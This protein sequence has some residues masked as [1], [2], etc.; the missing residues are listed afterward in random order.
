[1]SDKMDERDFSD[2][3]IDVSMWKKLLKIFRPYYK[4]V[5]ILCLFNALIAL[6]DT[7]FPVLNKYALD[8]YID[9]SVPNS[10][11]IRF[12]LI[13]LALILV[14]TF[15]HMFFFK[16]A[17]KAEMGYSHD[18]REK[19]FKKLQ[20]LSFAYY[21]VTPVGWLVSRLTSDIF[22]LSE[23]IAWSFAEFA[24]GIPMMV[25]A[26]AVMF[27]Y[28]TT[29]TWIVLASVP[30]IAVITFYFDKKML[31][32]YREVRK[33]N[34]IITN[35]YS[36]GINGA[37]TTKT[38]V[39]EDNNFKEFKQESENFKGSAIKAAYIGS[40]F[41]PLV[42]F[43]SSLCLSFIAYKGGSMVFEMTITFGTLMMFVQYAQQFF[44]PLRTLSMI[45][46]D[47]QMAQASGERIVYLLDQEPKITDK[48]EVIEKYGTL[49]E[50]KTENYEKIKGDI[51]FEH[52]DF[53]Y[54]KEEPVLSDFNLKVKAGQ[55]IALVGETGGGKSTIVNLLCRFYE[56]VNGKL[57]IDGKDYRER[58]IGWL[59]NN[60][61]YV[62]QAPHLFSGTVL[63]NIKYGSP[64]A[65]MDEIINAARLVNAHQFITELK[66]GY[67]T[68]VGEN[69]SKLS[70]GQKQLVCFAR[71][72][73]KNPSIFILDEATA[74]IDSETEAIIQYAIENIMKGKTSFVI[75]HRLST[76]VNCD[77]I[78]VI[79]HGKI[80]EDGNH[81]KL[82]SEKS[83]YYSL[84][85][86]QFNE[87]VID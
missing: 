63:D 24:W 11:L 60:L 66:D 68:E 19:C 22:R 55:T 16:V 72:V 49:F 8:Y 28:N 50:P 43:I 33:L 17:G 26:T 59:H 36:E 40:L 44:E 4:H 35:A 87:D 6:T 32:Q 12:I 61:G 9:P 65:T 34:S 13:Y 58:S 76:I 57:L 78:L 1:M 86:S 67:N 7:A 81:K 80:V 47:F 2:E 42:V 30:F 3:K 39:L 27:S 84:Y 82:M 77:R 64:D 56:P 45:M 38:L 48:P 23:I 20:E 70:T 71:A 53:Y 73:L 15:C 62:L 52:V 21:D 79:K 29:L 85:T 83:Y 46:Q 10:E 18:L 31:R 69:G 75:A 37:K 51:E 14:Q 25:F 54:N 41:R 74:S 5:V